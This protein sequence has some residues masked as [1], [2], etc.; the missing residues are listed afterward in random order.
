MSESLKR[1]L[2]IGLN[3]KS[4]GGRTRP[5]SGTF[6]ELALSSVR[7]FI[8]CIHISAWALLDRECTFL[9]ELSLPR[10][11]LPTPSQLGETLGAFGRGF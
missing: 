3:H 7:K 2:Y 1:V 6:A 9:E 5:Q 4:L 8:V 11:S 10:S